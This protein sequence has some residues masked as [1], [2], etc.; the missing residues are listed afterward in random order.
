M[1]Y[2]FNVG[3]IVETIDGVRGRIE[4]ICDC[5]KCRERGFLEP[6]YKSDSGD[7]GY[8][9]TKYQAENGFPSYRRIGNYIFNQKKDE[10]SISKKVTKVKNVI[11]HHIEDATY[12]IFDCRNI[13]GDSMETIYD[14]DGVSIAICRN[15]EYFEVFGLTEQ[16]FAE[17][18]SFYKDLVSKCN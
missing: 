5:D 12:G 15:W 2:K 3:D 7:Y 18:E 10:D 1:E 17:V 6:C 11:A 9:I 14:E 4:F 8:Y 13:A 16:E